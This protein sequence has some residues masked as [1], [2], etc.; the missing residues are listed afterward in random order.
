MIVAGSMDPFILFKTQQHTSAN[1]ELLTCFVLII[2]LLTLFLNASIEF[3]YGVVILV[4]AF[5]RLL[6]RG[7][8]WRHVHM[9]RHFGA[10][11]EFKMS[12]ATDTGSLCRTHASSYA[13]A[14]G[15][16]DDIVPK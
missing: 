1:R 5:G 11:C 8:P 7:V 4:L 9:L 3:A 12:T 13:V 16:T 6:R 2:T 14:N 10:V 15:S